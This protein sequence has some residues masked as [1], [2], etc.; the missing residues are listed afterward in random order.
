MQ[1]SKE[2]PREWRCAVALSAPSKWARELADFGFARRQGFTF[3]INALVCLPILF[4]EIFVVLAG[5]PG[6]E[7][8]KSARILVVADQFSAEIAFPFSEERCPIPV[9]TIGAF[10]GSTLSR[11]DT[12]FPYDYEADLSSECVS[13]TECF[14]HFVLGDVRNF[15]EL[16][17]RSLRLFGDLCG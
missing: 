14:G 15:C 7:G 10:E 8:E 13:A 3:L 1:G 5:L 11:S 9:R 12:E 2:Y 6:V 17:L 4:F 16:A